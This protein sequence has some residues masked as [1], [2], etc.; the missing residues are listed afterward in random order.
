MFDVTRFFL[1][2]YL[3]FKIFTTL[4]ESVHA[5]TTVFKADAAQSLIFEKKLVRF[6]MSS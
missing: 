3:S 4:S 6:G 5:E 2:G 1:W